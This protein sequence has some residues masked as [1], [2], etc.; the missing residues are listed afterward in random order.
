MKATENAFGWV[1]LLVHMPVHGLLTKS[2][3]TFSSRK[4]SAQVF[5]SEQGLSSFS[6]GS[7]P[8]V[9]SFMSLKSGSLR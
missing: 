5:P 2:E 3:K 8:T 6:F 9:V 7:H 4:P 1:V